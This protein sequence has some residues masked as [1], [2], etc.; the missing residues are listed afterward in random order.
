ML[1]T[2]RRGSKLHGP[3]ERLIGTRSGLPSVVEVWDLT[4]EGEHEFFADG[5]LVHNCADT[6]AMAQQVVKGRL[7]R[8]PDGDDGPRAFDPVKLLME[9]QIIDETTGLPLIGF[10]H[11]DEWTPELMAAMIQHKHERERDAHAANAI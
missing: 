5:V 11:P 6:L 7:S 1:G 8:E 3:T 2:S 10:V 9:G 4:V